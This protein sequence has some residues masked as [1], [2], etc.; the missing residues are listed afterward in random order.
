[1]RMA[2]LALAA[3]LVI[4]A[5]MY[6]Q[7]IKAP[8]YSGTNVEAPAAQ[9]ILPPAPPAITPHGMVVENTVVQVNEQVI[10]RSDVER[11]AEQLEQEAQQNHATPEQFAEMKKNMLRDMIDQQLLLSRAKE[12]GLNADADVIRQLD[13]IRKRNNMASLDDLEKAVRAQGLNYEDFKAQIRN[14]ILTQQ[15][16][17]DE[18]GRHLQMSP[19]EEQK[20]YDAHKDQFDQPEQVKLSEILVPLPENASADQIAQAEAK[21]NDIKSQIMKGADFADLA[22]KLSGGPSAQQGG[23]LGA[24]KRGALAKVLEDQ[25]FSLKPG[26]TTQPIRT[27]Q[28]FV[29]LKVN[30]HQMAGPAPLKDVEQQV[31]EAM[32]M[33][34]MQPAL[35]AYLSKLRNE[36]YIDIQPGFV[37][38]GSTGTESK[39]V[40]SA[41]VPPAP[42]KKPVKTATTRFDNQRSRPVISSPD[43]TGGRT[44]TGADAEIRPAA[45]TAEIDKNTGLAVIAPAKIVNGKVVKVK[46]EKVRFG[47]APRQ[48]LPGSEEGD[49]NAVLTTPVTPVVS[50]TAAP[51]ESANLA[52]NPLNA[53]APE[54]K[55]TRFAARAVEEKQKKATTLSSKKRE[56]ILAK[57]VAATAEES[58][59]EKIQAAPL[60]AAGNDESKKAPKPKRQK[61]QAKQRLE[62]KPATPAPTAPTVAPTA[63]PNLA[64]TDMTPPSNKP[65]PTADTTTLP[66]VGNPPPNQPTTTIPPPNTTPTTAGTPHPSVE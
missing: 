13:D 62:D 14:Q 30:D 46:K 60:S 27:R 61:G 11:S 2:A 20:F 43:T 6:A 47:Q 42:K 9:L 40:N 51:A 45:T 24:F 39:L 29:I 4:P 10:S 63:N 26:E 23:E 25:T 56:K 7:V 50:A 64:P 44:L 53:A 59:T 65:K 28:G 36:A 49:Q 31:Q 5:G 8:R 55:K 15:V 58:A 52:D 66:G 21:A 16:V 38:S 48:S 22:K 17:R 32:Y 12:L 35:R 18:V 19:G 1:M 41:Y 37:D 34:Q 54:Q 33:D 57:P 3:T